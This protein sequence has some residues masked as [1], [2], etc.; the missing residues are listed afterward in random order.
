MKYNMRKVKTVSEPHEMMTQ[1]LHGM[2][3]DLPVG[4]SV[5]LVCTDIDKKTEQ[6]VRVAVTN[7]SRK[8]EM[9]FTCRKVQANGRKMRFLIHHAFAE[10]RTP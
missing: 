8:W 5:E 2:L 3:E 10:E 4:E 7:F 6:R 9:R 1:E